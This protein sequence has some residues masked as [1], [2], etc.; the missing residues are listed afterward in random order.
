MEMEYGV[1]PMKKKI[2][3]KN[4]QHTNIP[5]LIIYAKKKNTVRNCMFALKIVVVCAA[6][7]DSNSVFE[8]IGQ[9]AIIAKCSI[10]SQINLLFT[11]LSFLFETS[12]F[13]VHSF[14]FA[15]FIVKRTLTG[16]LRSMIC[17]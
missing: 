9:H 7:V 14:A 12:F 11:D 4:Q 3:Q 1:K 13:I 17:F 15:C 10:H 16:T 2:T 8:C 6:Q 5:N